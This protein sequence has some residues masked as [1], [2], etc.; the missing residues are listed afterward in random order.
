MEVHYGL[1]KDIEYLLQSLFLSTPDM[2]VVPKLYHQYRYLFNTILG[3]AGRQKPSKSLPN[4]CRVMKEYW[5]MIKA[6]NEVFCGT[7]E[8][9]EMKLDHHHPAATAADIDSKAQS[10]D[11]IPPTTAAAASS[12]SPS[13]I[14]EEVYEERVVHVLDSVGRNVDSI[15]GLL[16]DNDTW[17]D[18]KGH[19]AKSASKSIFGTAR[20]QPQASTKLINIMCRWATSESR[21][22]DWKAY[23]VASIL[24][25]WRDQNKGQDNKVLLQDAL[26]RFLDDEACSKQNETTLDSQMMNT[27]EEGM[28]YLEKGCIP[29]SSIYSKI[30]IYASNRSYRKDK[31][32]CHL[33]IRCANSFATIFI[34]K[35]LA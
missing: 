27:L 11:S 6:R 1:Q 32:A 35:I 24:S 8:E 33:F 30:L 7:L 2:F 16:L 10:N 20:L 18:V 26:I 9:N 21:Y 14:S 4:V 22:G 34:P 5:T 19:T 25:S 13:S 29:F 15:T 17:V 31:Y 28:R 23:L 3:D 12:P